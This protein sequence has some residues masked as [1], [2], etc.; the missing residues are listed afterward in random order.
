MSGLGRQAT[1]IDLHA[2]NILR[3]MRTM[4]NALL[5]KHSGQT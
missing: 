3:V 5:S 4:I 1:D 2:R